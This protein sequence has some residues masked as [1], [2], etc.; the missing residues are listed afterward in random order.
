MRRPTRLHRPSSRSKPS[1]STLTTRSVWDSL[2]GEAGRL[3][4]VH[5]PASTATA[6]LAVGWAICSTLI[7]PG[8]VRSR[9]KDSKLAG[10][11][12]EQLYDNALVAAGLLDD[13][14]QM[15]PRLQSLLGALVEP[16]E[17]PTEAPTEAPTKAETKE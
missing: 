1:R 17:E 5:E 3:L 15:L 8:F 10:L 6:S 2:H 16:D 12:A 13:A 11:V 4:V 14:R 7:P 9:E